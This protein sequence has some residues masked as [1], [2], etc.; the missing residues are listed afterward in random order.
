MPARGRLKLV[1]PASI[2]KVKGVKAEA[3]ACLWKHLVLYS[4][5]LFLGRALLLDSLAPFGSAYAAAVNLVFGRNFWP[6]WLAVLLGEFW[7]LP[8]EGRF[9]GAVTLL[10]TALVL[11]LVP[12]KPLRQPLN[13]S[14]LVGASSLFLRSFFLVLGHPTPH[15][16][17]SLLFEGL[18]TGVLTYLFLRGLAAWR[19]KGFNLSVE[20]LFCLFVLGT[21][22]IAGT[23]EISWGVVSLK[24]V[25]TRLSLLLAAQAGGA[26]AGAAV[27]ALLGAIPGLSFSSL[28]QA[29]PNYAFIGLLAGS[30]RSFGRV[31]QILGFGLGNVLLVLPDSA[32]LEVLT[33]I[34]A[35]TVLS[36]VLYLLLPMHWYAGLRVAYAGASLPSGQNLARL[37]SWVTKRLDSWSRVYQELAA[38]F[39][40]AERESRPVLPEGEEEIVEE[41]KNR[42]CSHC[43]LF[44]V[45]WER[46]GE[47][48]RALYREALSIIRRKGSISP[49]GFPSYFAQRC[50]RLSDLTLTLSLL[51]EL[52]RAN[53]F[54]CR[55]VGESRAVVAEQ[56]QGFARALQSFV[57]ELGENLKRAAAVEE[58]LLRLVAS[59]GLRVKELNVHLRPD[60]R[61][62]VEVEV[63]ARA[64]RGELFC[65]REMADLVSRVARWPY[66]VAHANCPWR[67]GT[68]ECRF[69]L[70]PS[71]RYRLALGAASAS[72]N[73]VSGDTYTT[74]SLPGG[75]CALVLSDG[76]GSG[77]GAAMESAT[78]VSLLELLLQAG[79]G[80]ELAVK[81]ANSLILFRSP[82]DG[83]ATLDMAVVDLYTGKLR[84]VKI[85]ASPGFVYRRNGVVEIIRE[86]SLP[87]GVLSPIDVVVVERELCPGDLVVLVSDGLLEAYRGE[88]K[89]TW[90]AEVL[91]ELKGEDP[92]M[93]G[94]FLL[95]RAR[96]VGG[97]RL[98]D[99]ATVVAARLLPA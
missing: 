4:I 63:A 76:M 25:L 38:T 5:G 22:I 94:K 35:E 62:E 17:I 83:F 44:R 28:P 54:W 80:E 82:G 65:Q 6:V 95:D 19:E 96:L 23:G 15:G 78:A 21:G 11:G 2:P 86:P 14:L 85:G 64:C 31:G 60:G 32:S 40:A 69:V 98:Q 89:E 7:S 30:F 29:I 67:Q 88:D 12:A 9:S 18:F 47:Q 33:S 46:E 52:Y 51:W 42:V 8:P 24:G 43:P 3:K 16:Y 71:L 50:V 81:L 84:W 75:R 58:E 55:K 13:A 66:A 91:Q 39:S 26:G 27:G 68:E 61:V 74:I 99:D 73:R 72:F 10:G 20:E 49:E 56:F 92:E 45:C 77:T 57:G 37:D 97:G 79:F 53:R 48:T 93:V 34:V 87:A 70:Y 59:G 41:A 90:W 36:I 1:A